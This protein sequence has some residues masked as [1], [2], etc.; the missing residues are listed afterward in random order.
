[1]WDHPDTQA[2]VTAISTGLTFTVVGEPT[3]LDGVFAAVELTTEPPTE[4]PLFMSPTDVIRLSTLLVDAMAAVRR[5]Y[6]E[7]DR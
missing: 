2:V 5:G 1:M 3:T 7:E 4:L 6:Q